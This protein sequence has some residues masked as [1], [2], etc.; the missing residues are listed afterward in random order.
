MDKC[1][2]CGATE[3]I[4]T[5]DDTTICGACEVEQPSINDIVKMIAEAE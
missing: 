5:Y 1:Y 3:D 4:D 2:R